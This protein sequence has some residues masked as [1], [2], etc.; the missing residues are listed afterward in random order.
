MEKGLIVKAIAFDLAGSST[1]WKEL[2]ITSKNNFFMQPLNCRKIWAF[3]DPPHYLKLLRN[4]FLDTGLVLKDGTVLTINIFEE[5]FKKDRGEY[6]LC[7]KLKPNLLTVR[8]NERQKV[9]PA[10]TFFSATTAKALLLTG[11]Q[12]VTE[13]FELVDSFFDIMNSSKLHPPSNKPLQAG[14]GLEK[15]FS[16]QEQILQ[17]MK[18]EMNGIRVQ[19]KKRPWP[20]LL[21]YFVV[22]V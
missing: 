15:Y 5:V 22:M 2:E 18:E 14:Y 13:F 7:L 3:A 8:G 16:Q 6:K 21:H 1:L 12:R 19:G 11:N 10:K 4:H 17:N 20:S 9:S